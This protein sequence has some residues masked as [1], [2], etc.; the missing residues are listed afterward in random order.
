[1][2]EALELAKLLGITKPP[3]RRRTIMSAALDSCRDDLC[4]TDTDNQLSYIEK[5]DKTSY[6]ICSY[7]FLTRRPQGLV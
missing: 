2:K 6:I 5:Q 4:L 1:M 3:V 7:Y